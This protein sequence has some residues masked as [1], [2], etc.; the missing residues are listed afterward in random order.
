MIKYMSIRIILVGICLILLSIS[1]FSQVSDKVNKD[2]NKFA[3]SVLN[4]SEFKDSTAIYT[5]KLQLIVDRNDPTRAVLSTNNST[6]TEH[7]KGLN[8]LK[9]FD[10]RALMGEHKRVA[11]LIPIAVIITD[12]NHGKQCIDANTISDKLLTLLSDFKLDTKGLPIM[13]MFPL[14][15]TL[16]KKVYD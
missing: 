15:T 12:S 11:F 1:S 14:I 2:F 7:I 13:Q 16:D 9:N 10:F 6:V 3:A 8:S 5:C 4:M